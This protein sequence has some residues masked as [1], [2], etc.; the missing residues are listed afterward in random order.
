MTRPIAFALLTLTIGACAGSRKG[1][2]A[3]GGSG[4]TTGGAANAPGSAATGT[5]AANTTGLAPAGGGAQRGETCDDGK[6]AAGLQC[7]TYYGIAGPSGPKFTSC[8]NT[9][10]P[11]SGKPRCPAGLN[12]VT[13]A[14]GPGSVCRP[15]DT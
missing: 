3:G 2:D 14:D 11:V 4:A 7:I 15:S 12:C 6:C 8:E 5:P 13:I 1:A 9:C 10:D